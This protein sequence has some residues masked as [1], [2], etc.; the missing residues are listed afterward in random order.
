[1]KKRALVLI[2]AA[3]M[4]FASC[5]S[6]SVT[7]NDGKTAADESVNDE[8]VTDNE[9]SVTESESSSEESL[10]KD[11]LGD[12]DFEGASFGI[13]TF[14]NGNFHYAVTADE[15]LAVPIND[16]MYEA[17]TDIEDRFNIDL[18]QILYPDFSDEPRTAVI[19]GDSSADL[20]RMR[21][22]TDVSWWQQ[23]LIVTADEVPNINLEKPYWDKSINESLTIAG[24][25]FVALSAF[26]LCTYDLTF[27][28]IFNKDMITNYSLDNPYEEVKNGT[29]TMDK[30][31][32]M[33]LTVVSDVDGNG[34]YDENDRYGYLS[35]P[36]MAAPGFWIGAG[37][38]LIE[39]NENDIPHLAIAE[40]S[41]ITFWDKLL[42]I[43]YSN[44]QYYGIDEAEDIPPT[45]RKMFSE[46]K[47][48]FMD[49][50]FFFIEE[51]REMESDFGII[52]Y[53]KYN[54]EQSSY[55]TRLCYYMPTVVPI[56]IT[57]ERLDRAG[58]ML[59]ALACEYA[60]NVVPAYYETALKNKAA[61]DE[62][63]QEMLDVIFNS[64]V[65]DLGDA[66]FC[67]ELRDGA[68]R[69]LFDSKKNTL[70]SKS[71]SLEK[72]MSRKLSELPGCQ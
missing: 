58:V 64:R 15:M 7:E 43:T 16:A 71:K 39:K 62:E 19:A 57:G 18:Q 11:D 28:L 23:N 17:T 46:G 37:L 69:Q 63:S 61:R 67:S 8:S 49:M 27:A 3:L 42:D 12:F 22:G 29:W 56:T 55:A 70:A 25:Q 10:Y 52:P 33:M 9:A 35:H 45:A 1:M 47:A 26:D 38:K 20:I 14:E 51:L 60:N 68:M 53:P 4:M 31:N 24:K 32:D 5:S 36:K 65:I 13:M 34:T 44:N 6:G 50:S 54:E 2:L 41:F 59:E 30:M 40:E 72:I 21:C 48:L 66:T